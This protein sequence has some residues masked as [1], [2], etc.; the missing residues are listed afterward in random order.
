MELNRKVRISISAGALLFVWGRNIPAHADTTA[1]GTYKAK[2]AACH[3]ADGSG[4][5]AVGKKLGTHDFRSAEV[6]KMSDA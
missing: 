2:Y 6:Q 5:A 4:D 3:G 1:E